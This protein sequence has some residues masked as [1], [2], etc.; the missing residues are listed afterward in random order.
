LNLDEAY[1]MIKESDKPYY[2][3]SM[4]RG[5]K[6]PFYVGI[7][8]GRRIREHSYELTAFDKG[9]QPKPEKCNAHKLNIMRKLRDSG[10]EID[11]QI[12]SFHDTWEEACEAEI[13]LIAFIGRKANGGPL[14]NMTDGGDGAVGR[15]S[16]EKQKLAASMANSKPKDY[17]AIEKTLATKKSLGPII[18]SFKGKTHTEEWKAKASLRM[19]GENHPQYGT[20]GVDHHNY[21]TIRTEETRAKIRTA[22]SN[23]DLSCTEERKQQLRDYWNSQPILKCEHCGKESSFK[24]AMVRFHFDKCKMNPNKSLVNSEAEDTSVS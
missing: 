7:G 17:K 3:Y 21:G 13:E 12:M 19:S 1:K 2:C 10:E 8:K 20:G 5:I 6:S 15:P 18:S 22:L 4:D 9:T 14:V 23:L 16:S 24:P 11:Y